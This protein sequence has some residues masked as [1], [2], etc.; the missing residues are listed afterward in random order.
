MDKAK[1]KPK[2]KPFNRNRP[3]TDA[4]KAHDLFQ[5]LGFKGTVA[6]R[7]DY[8]H[9]LD[10]AS[11][12]SLIVASHKDMCSVDNTFFC[13]VPFAAY[14]H[15]CSTL[16]HARLLVI[17]NENGQN[18]LTNESVTDLIDDRTIMPKSISDYL[19][20]ISNTL[21]PQGFQLRIN[22]P[23]IIF[24]QIAAAG[25]PDGSFGIC[26][27]VNHQAYETHFSP[28]VTQGLMEATIH[29]HQHGQHTGEWTPLPAALIPENGLPN[30]NLLGYYP[31]AKLN[32]KA[33]AV[34]N[35]L[36]DCSAKGDT[37]RGRLRFNRE[38]MA[39]VT[40]HIDNL[41]IKKLNGLPKSVPN[42]S[43]LA[44]VHTTIPIAAGQQL[45]PIPG[46]IWS[47]TK[48]CG[49]STGRGQLYAYKRKKSENG[50]CHCYY[51]AGKAPVNWDE[52]ANDNFLMVAP[53]G[54]VNGSDL[55]LL[56]DCF[57]REHSPD[58]DVI[59]WIQDWV[60]SRY[61]I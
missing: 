45:T 30:R 53:Y 43:L 5:S 23:A 56:R 61:R 29:A 58:M 1:S 60:R 48:L 8:L 13:N 17:A 39:H 26:N 40:M 2:S 25:Y 32:P 59:H 20:H 44:F 38:L 46:T 22:Y 42:D 27:A 51:V 14:Q 54:P 35:N 24:P 50:L 12:G 7:N 3:K 19:A 47:S 18:L 10:H 11:Y 31:T 57:F 4:A 55:P 6:D 16:L 36:V 9:N 33:L 15:Y 49:V 52:T 37:L 41:K 34:L 28:L 21:A